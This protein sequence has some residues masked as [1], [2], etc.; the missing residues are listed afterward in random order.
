MSDSMYDIAIIQLSGNTYYWALRQVAP[1]KVLA[2]SQLIAEKYLIE[3][4]AYELA[5]RFNLHVVIEER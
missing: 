2:T 1:Y 5:N 3:A 4:E